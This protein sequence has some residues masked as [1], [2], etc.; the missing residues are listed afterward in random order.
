MVCFWGIFLLEQWIQETEN[1]FPSYKTCSS[2]ITLR[3]AIADK[4]Y[5][6]DGSKEQKGDFYCFCQKLYTDKGS[7]GL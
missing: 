6:I 4:Q 1:A 3:E 2:Q 5:F 7:S